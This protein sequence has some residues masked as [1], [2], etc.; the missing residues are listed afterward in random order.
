MKTQIYRAKKIDSD[1]YVEGY[2]Y[3]DNNEF[4]IIKEDAI[5]GA[6]WSG[7]D[8]TCFNSMLI[9]NVDPSTLAISFPDMLDKNGKPIFASLSEGGKG[10]DALENIHYDIR[11]CIVLSGCCGITQ[12]I[13]NVFIPFEDLD[14]RLFKVLGKHI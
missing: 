6:D 14:T 3:K 13:N 2:L 10:G 8:E 11:N 12:G 9:H 7:R 4:L 5:D 1:D